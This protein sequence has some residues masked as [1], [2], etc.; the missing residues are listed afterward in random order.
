MTQKS[1]RQDRRERR[2]RPGAPENTLVEAELMQDQRDGDHSGSPARFAISAP[3]ELQV[4]VLGL[5]RRTLE[6]RQHAPPRR[7]VRRRTQARNRVGNGEIDL[8]GHRCRAWLDASGVLRADHVGQ[9]KLDLVRG[10]WYAPS[11]SGEPMRPEY[12]RR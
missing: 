1:Q 8:H 5:G 3:K 9:R 12:G 4:D 7:P 6:A 2:P 10:S 11:S